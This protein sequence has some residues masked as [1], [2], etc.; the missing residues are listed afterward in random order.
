MF[1]FLPDYFLSMKAFFQQNNGVFGLYFFFL[2]VGGVILLSYS[3]AGIHLAINQYHSPFFDEFFKFM[4]FLGSGWGVAILAII[5]LIKKVRY[6]V[7][8]LWGTLITT[9]LVQGTKH[10]IFP[11]TLRPVAY[12]QHIHQQLYLVPGVTMHYLDSF[13]SGHSASA[14]GYFIIL[15]FLSRKSW[16]KVLWLVLACLIGFSRIYLSQHFLVDVEFG[17][18]VGIISMLIPVL[19]FET[20][21]PDKFNHPLFHNRKI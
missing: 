1:I 9:L 14:F 19:Y 2:L 10:L 13:P 15:I 20:H 17:S 8:F 21:Y 4:T 7:I 11:G 6:G 3:K 16:Q 12:F 18:L 5:L